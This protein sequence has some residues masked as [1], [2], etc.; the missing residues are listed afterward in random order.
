[1]LHDARRRAEARAQRRRLLLRRQR[2]GNAGPIEVEERIVHRTGGSR[3]GSRGR[4][5]GGLLCQFPP[6]LSARHGLHAPG[7]KLVAVLV[8]AELE[9]IRHVKHY[10][11]VERLTRL[12]EDCFARRRRERGGVATAV[13]HLVRA[14][15]QREGPQR[16]IHHRVGRRDAELGRAVRVRNGAQYAVRTREGTPPTRVRSAPAARGRDRGWRAIGAH[17]DAP[18]QMD[19]GARRC[20]QRDAFEYRILTDRNVDLCVDDSGRRGGQ[21]FAPHDPRVRSRLLPCRRGLLAK[22]LRGLGAALLNELR[23]L[24]ARRL[25]RPRDDPVHGAPCAARL[26]I[27][28]THRGPCVVDDLERCEPHRVLLP[29]LDELA[30]Q[31]AAARAAHALLLTLCRYL[32]CCLQLL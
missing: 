7:L 27:S 9:A 10:G 20:V 22:L 21:D 24:E 26:A 18:Q 19:L 16:P 3:A 1:M 25:A 15:A 23:Q 11:D 32:R 30:R 29:P 6:D 4:R 5:R 12:D 8:Q 28:E 13:E 31:R 14:E 17:L 2:V